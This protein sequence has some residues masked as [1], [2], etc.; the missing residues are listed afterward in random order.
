MIDPLILF[1]WIILGVF[2]YIAISDRNVPDY[3]ILLLK[4]FQ[5]HLIRFFMGIRLRAR[6]EYDRF[7]LKQRMKKYLRK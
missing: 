5:I 2:G 6:L 4:L 1:W 3:C 7:I